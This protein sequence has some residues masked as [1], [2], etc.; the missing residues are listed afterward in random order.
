MGEAAVTL[1]DSLVYLSPF[2]IARIRYPFDFMVAFTVVDFLYFS[3][4]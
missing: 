3:I 4:G 2:S 1:D